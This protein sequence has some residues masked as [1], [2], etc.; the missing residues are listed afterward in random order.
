VNIVPLYVRDLAFSLRTRL[1]P[2]LQRPVPF[3]AD[4]RAREQMVLLQGSLRHLLQK[5]VHSVL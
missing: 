4:T 5:L 1:P 2:P 3:T